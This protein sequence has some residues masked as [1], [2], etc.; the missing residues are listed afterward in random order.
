MPRL[1]LSCHSVTHI[2]NEVS[3]IEKSAK[4]GWNSQCLAVEQG[5]LAMVESKRGKD[6]QARKRPGWDEES[7]KEPLERTQ[8]MRCM[9]I[10]SVIHLMIGIAL[11]VVA[12]KVDPNFSGQARAEGLHRKAA[13]DLFTNAS[14]EPAGPNVVG[15][16]MYPCPRPVPA[17]VGQTYITYQPLEPK[18][19]LYRHHHVYKTYN[20][21][22]HSRTSVHWR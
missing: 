22:S 9:F 11:L 15:A 10:R 8:T 19:F 18:E 14:V 2:A 13:G 6:R 12:T 16:Q 7:A 21:E 4:L 20:E 3:M 1:K 5:G 17:M